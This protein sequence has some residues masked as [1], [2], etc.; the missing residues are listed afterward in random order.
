MLIISFLVIRPFILAIFLGALLAY[1]FYPLYKYL[2]K[3]F[4]NKTVSAL[5]LCIFIFLII[6]VPMGFMINLLVKESYVLYLLVKQKLAI[7]FFEKCSSDFCHNLKDFLQSDFVSSQLKEITK[8][9][10]DLIIRKG[11]SLLMSLPR[12]LLNMFV[13][14]FTMFYFMKDGELLLKRVEKFFSNHKN[15]YLHVLN[16]LKEII[17]GVIFGYLLVAIIQGAL[18][19]LGFFLFGIPSPLFWGLAMALLALIP[20]LGTGVIWVP[21]SIILLLQGIF[22]GSNFL[23]FKGVGLFAYSLLIVSSIDNILRPKLIGGRA[24]VHTAIIMI[25]IFGGLVVIGPLGVIIGPLVLAL[26]AELINLYLNDS[27]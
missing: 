24:K 2:V 5:L 23:I 19:A 26:T 21:A 17:H 13:I 18:G 20:F 22:Q 10:T 25:G 4:R 1:I 3:K 7:G 6:L 27:K 9:V 16:R 8:T 15:K 11:S 12:L 14:L